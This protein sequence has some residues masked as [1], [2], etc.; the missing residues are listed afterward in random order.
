MF[1][2]KTV[3]VALLVAITIL[4]A[5]FTLNSVAIAGAGPQTQNLEA[6]E[7]FTLPTCASPC[8]TVITVPTTTV[9]TLISLVDSSATETFLDGAPVVYADRPVSGTHVIS[10]TVI[11][12]AS[13]WNEKNAW[14]LTYTEY[15]SLA[16]VPAGTI[17]ATGAADNLAWLLM[18]I[19]GA[20][21]I[22]AAFYTHK[23]KI[24]LSRGLAIGAVLAF[25]F[26][27]SLGMPG[28]GTVEAGRNFAPPP[29][30]APT[31]VATPV[32]P[33]VEPTTTPTE[34][35]TLEP[36]QAPTEAPK[37]TETPAP[38]NTPAPT[39]VPTKQTDFTCTVNVHLN[40]KSEVATSALACPG[41]NADQHNFAWQRFTLS[42]VNNIF[43]KDG[44]LMFDRANKVVTDVAPLDVVGIE[45]EKTGLDGDGNLTIT[46][47]NGD[48]F[49]MV[50]P[51]ASAQKM[52]AKEIFKTL[53][54]DLD[55]WLD[56]EI[57]VGAIG[58][59]LGVAVVILVLAVLVLV[60][61]FVLPLLWR[62][63]RF[64]IWRPIVWLYRGLRFKDWGPQRRIHLPARKKKL[65]LT[66]AKPETKEEPK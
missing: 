46:L 64:L 21:L 12:Q 63:I 10:S 61:F 34:A 38:T 36:T 49:T 53:Q 8:V 48:S 23:R 5:A 19:L 11:G 3:M 35:P 58:G 62:L 14:T 18:A 43:V 29:T 9:G 30:K 40:E 6:N 66:I 20:I 17:P 42:P 4:A 56:L 31:V 13:V 59:M 24:K 22:G 39:A 37:A 57:W 60:I 65:D 33:T 25:I 32:P 44:K 51:E 50:K 27:F 47:T 28:N 26:A 55:V 16:D 54:S 2:K 15:P 45:P 52:T 7:P 1:S 41:L